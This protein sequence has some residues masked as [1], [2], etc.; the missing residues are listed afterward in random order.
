[1]MPNFLL[2]WEM[3]EW[4]KS[5]GCTVYDF[6]GISGN[7]DPTN[8]LYGL[9]R[10]KKGF[11]GVYT[12]FIGEFDLVFDSLMYKLWDV[13]IPLMKK[14]RSKLILAKKKLRK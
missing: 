2:Q 4:A 12:E 10:F 11:N 8:P 5:I 9:F 1:V 7:L 14:V 13:G 3:I 6:R